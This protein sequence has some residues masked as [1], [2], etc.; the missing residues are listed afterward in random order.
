MSPLRRAPYRL[1]PWTRA[2]P[3][4]RTHLPR[5]PGS[6]RPILRLA[7]SP[8]PRQRT[9]SQCLQDRQ[10]PSGR[11]GDSQPAALTSP[12]GARPRPGLGNP[13]QACP[14]LLQALSAAKAEAAAPPPRGQIGL[15]RIPGVLWTRSPPPRSALPPDPSKSLGCQTLAPGP[16]TFSVTRGQGEGG[17]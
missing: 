13:E 11:G 1:F 10:A 5:A 3:R 4:G 12:S 7:T 17:R 2:P 9:G 6:R 16:V 15:N 14:S 8:G